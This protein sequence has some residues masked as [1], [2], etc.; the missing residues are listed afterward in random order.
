MKVIVKPGKWVTD[1]EDYHWYYRSWNGS[2]ITTITMN[3]NNMYQTSMNCSIRPFSTLNE[4][5]NFVEKKY[6][7]YV[8]SLIEVEE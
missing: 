1:D 5:K 7:E 3:S 4:A 2:H 6:R 8:L